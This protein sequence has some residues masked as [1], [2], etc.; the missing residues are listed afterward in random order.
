MAEKT[1]LAAPKPMVRPKLSLMFAVLLASFWPRRSAVLKKTLARKARML[2]QVRKAL[3]DGLEAAYLIPESCL[4]Q[5]A[6]LICV[7]GWATNGT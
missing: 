2:L 3:G 4:L 1:A 7:G 6:W 5:Q